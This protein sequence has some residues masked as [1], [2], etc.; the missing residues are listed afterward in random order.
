MPANP[1]A[2]LQLLQR[3]AS[4]IDAAEE[5]VRDVLD[6]LPAAIYRT[7]AGGV[8]TY[9]NE[10]AVSL[11]GY[12]PEIGKAEWCGSWKLFRID[13]TPL[14][15]DECPMAVALKTGRAIR[16]IEAI[17]ERPDGSRVRFL[18]YPTPLY[19]AAGKPKGAV[20]MLVDLTDR[21][22]D[23]QGL[24]QLASIVESSNDAI[25]SKDLDGI[26]QSW[27]RG[28]ERL[29]GYRPEEA[30][31]KSVTILI[32]SDRLGEEAD[33]LARIRRGERVETYETIRQ[34]KD[35]SQLQ[36]SLTVSPVK[37]VDGRVIGA[38]KIARDITDRKAAEEQQK[39]LIAE[40]RHRI[41]NSLATVQ[42]IASQTLRSASPEERAAC[43]GRLH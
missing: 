11:W 2:T 23:R 40:M 21:D 22:R 41:K 13:G 16:G 5:K 37:D 27:N 1:E 12:R 26:I 36:V 25:V 17:A 7:D 6:A 28:A 32:P 9:Y 35:G 42:S 10:A 15:H 20:N 38:S 33:I 30:I 8:L 29:F 4:S 19:D 3:A 18:P 43:I 24:S 14:P 34:R 31:G 39:L